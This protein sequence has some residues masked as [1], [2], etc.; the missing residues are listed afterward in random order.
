MRMMF[1]G[2]KRGLL[3]VVYSSSVAAAHPRITVRQAYMSTCASQDQIADRIQQQLTKLLAK[4][5]RPD[6]GHPRAVA[7][8]SSVPPAT[9]PQTAAQIAMS[10]AADLGQSPVSFTPSPVLVPT[11]PRESIWFEPP[12]AKAPSVPCN[13][14]LSPCDA[15]K[16]GD[17]KSA[18]VSKSASSQH[19]VLEVEQAAMNASAISLPSVKSGAESFSRDMPMQSTLCGPEK[20]GVD[21]DCSAEK[22]Q[23]PSLAL[24]LNSRRDL[25][26]ANPMAEMG[27]FIEP[28]MEGSSAKNNANSLLEQSIPNLGHSN[29]L[30]MLRD[31]EKNGLDNFV[32][33][34]RFGS[35]SPDS[36]R[37]G[38]VTA[39]PSPLPP[40][41]PMGHDEPPLKRPRADTAPKTDAFALG[42]D[43][44][45]PGPFDEHSKGVHLPSWN[46]HAIPERPLSALG[47][48]LGVARSPSPLALMNGV[49]KTPSPSGLALSG[50]TVPTLAFP[51]LVN[52]EPSFQNQ[53]DANGPTN[54]VESV[55]EREAKGSN[56]V[57]L[58]VAKKV[59]AKGDS[60]PPGDSRNTSE[61]AVTNGSEASAGNGV[62]CE[63]CGIS[64]AKRSN[65]L[66]HIQTVHNR[67]KQFECDLCGTKFGL[68]ADLGR[69]RFR[70]HE[71]RAY[72]C[73]TCG[74][75]F[76][77]QGQLELHIRVTH[78]EDSRPWECKRCRIRFGRKSSLTRHEQTV[79]QQ[80]RFACRVCKKSYSQKFDA[81]RHEQKIHGLT[82]KPT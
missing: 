17:H 76:A 34:V 14:E 77:E 63:I 75:S 81:F 5:P 7:M 43:A 12:K 8:E 9:A 53:F 28:I 6:Q 32:S 59:A 80:T 4:V 20:A 52:Q 72:C 68:K 65:K 61:G 42:L 50:P 47:R 44:G 48:A 78:E 58:L 37:L 82:D 38:G 79:H 49:H 57:T 64:F 33:T 40:P 60:S 45:W 74:K 35:Q 70:I 56:N 69:H 1:H 41:P 29:D 23:D 26:A 54:Q 11:L 62:C 46:I 2:N 15:D 67:L 10:C 24:I 3:T 21:C 13:P 66:R 16:C 22:M 27:T 31:D 51:K 19:D 30:N 36:G 39:L 71:S 73:K 55:T 18:S 25:P